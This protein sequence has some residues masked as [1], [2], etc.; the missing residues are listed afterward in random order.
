MPVDPRD[1]VAAHTLSRGRCY[2]Y[3]APCAYEDLAKV[4]FSRDPL[5]RLQSLHRRWFEFFLPERIALVE[6][7]TVREARV[8]EGA[9]KRE[10]AELNTPVPLT[11]AREAAGHGEWY[12]G[13]SDR[14]ARFVRHLAAEG[15]R[16]HAPADA[17]LRDALQA[18]ADLLY[19]WTEAALSV[20]ELELRA[21]PTPAQ[22]TV[23]DALD[24][25]AAFGLEVQER[26]PA[27]VWRWYRAGGGRS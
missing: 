7:D 15:H 22:R 1:P 19:S 5:Q 21:G 2:L 14:L 13:A 12:R 9:L 20:D 4:G 24:A 16:V 11:I 23:R 18:R 10:L 25:Y 6:L 26:V 8:L 3:L 27:A 17:W